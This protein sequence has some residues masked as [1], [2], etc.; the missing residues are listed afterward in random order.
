MDAIKS[1][2]QI[3]DPAV[4]PHLIAALRDESV[5]M[6]K[7]AAYALG[8]IGDPAA[9]PPL[10]T[11]LSD[12]N[13]WVR[14]NATSALESFDIHEAHAALDEYYAWQQRP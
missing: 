1:L 5:S 6:R 14:R 8:Q 4:V 9:V 2:G 3:G 11:T 13:E 7:S 12:N 10:I